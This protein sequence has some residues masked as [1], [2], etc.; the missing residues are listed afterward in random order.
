M[1][2]KLSVEW[3]LASLGMTTFDELRSKMLFVPNA[4]LL[5]TKFDT[6]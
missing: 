6:L 4:I 2:D 5:V 3:A 1:S